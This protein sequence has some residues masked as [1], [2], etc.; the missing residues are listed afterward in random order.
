MNLFEKQ[1]PQKKPCTKC[2]KVKPLTE[3]P[4]RSKKEQTKYRARCKECSNAIEMKRKG[5]EEGYLDD[6]YNGILKRCKWVQN[7]IDPR[8]KKPRKYTDA[9]KKSYSVHVTKEQFFELWKKHKEKYGAK[10]AFLMEPIV[11]ERGKGHGKGISLKNRKNLSVDRLDVEQGYTKDNI[12]FTSHFVNSSKNGCTIQMAMRMLELFVERFPDDRKG[13]F[14]Q[15]F[16]YRL[17]KFFNERYEK[18]MLEWKETNFD[19]KKMPLKLQKRQGKNIIE[20]LNEVE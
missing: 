14:I 2:K 11:I 20:I 19:P 17:N 1:L 13:I 6:M 3:F 15:I 4:L 16:A 7:D 5:T 12:V 10:D 8:N 18:E 9:D